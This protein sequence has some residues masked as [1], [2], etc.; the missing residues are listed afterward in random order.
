MARV[1]FVGTPTLAVPVL[2]AVVEEHEVVAVI[3]QPD[4]PKGRSKKPVAPPVKAWAEEHGLLVHQPTKLND[5]A[6]EAWLNDLKPDIG[7]VA[8]YGRMLKQPILDVPPLGY[9]NLHPSLLPRH[10]GA[11][12]IQ[13]ALL[14]GD[15]VTGVT[16]MRVVLAMDAGDILLQESTPITP[17]ENAEELS[18]RLSEM[19]AA[20]MVRGIDL[21]VAGTANFRPQEPAAVTESRLIEKQDGIVRWE[22]PASDIHNLVRAL[23]PW[24]SAQCVYKGQ[25]CRIHRS[26]VVD[27][28]DQVAPGT[29]VAVEKNRI[30]V[31][32]AENGLAIE[33]FQV[34]G[35]K[36][37]AMGD[38]LRGKPI[39]VG[40]CFAEVG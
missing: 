18:A 31:A 1:V 4:R 19:G 23:Y 14:E 29:V 9:L 13:T 27:E 15:S 5:G 6:F 32:T 12:P 22:R 28:V 33:I 25:V 34:P 8:A 30:V 39:A 21:A 3:C 10:R 26:A 38:F 20:L 40:E 11:S 36:A 2:A 24:P 35:K 37:M 17:E 16:I 7:V